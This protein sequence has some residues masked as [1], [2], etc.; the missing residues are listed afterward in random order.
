MKQYNY[1]KICK[2]FSGRHTHPLLGRGE[3]ERRCGI[4]DLGWVIIE[5]GVHHIET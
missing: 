3:V 2:L 1:L 5:E 4:N